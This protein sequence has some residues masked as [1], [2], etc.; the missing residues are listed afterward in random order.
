M[1][2]IVFDRP[3]ED[4]ELSLDEELLSD[5]EEPEEEPDGGDAF[6]VC[7]PA[8]AEGGGVNGAAE[9]P[10]MPAPPI[11]GFIGSGGAP[12]GA[13]PNPPGVIGGIA[14]GTEPPGLKGI[15]GL[16]GGAPGMAGMLG[17]TPIPPPVIVL[18][19]NRAPHPGHD[20]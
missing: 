5:E 1:S 17:I 3:L 9:P 13:P 8:E 4:E 19:L 7:V 12:A 2:L 11:A 10:P 20:A 16:I 18:P 15:P 14:G 6:G